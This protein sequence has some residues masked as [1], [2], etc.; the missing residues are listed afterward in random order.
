MKNKRLLIAALLTCTALFAQNQTVTVIHA[1]TLIDGH[2]DQ[3]LKNRTIVIRGN[4]IESV[5]DASSPVPAGAAVVD[6]SQATVLP[7]LID[8]HTHLFLQGEDPAL[9]GYDIQLLK[10]S[11]VLVPRAR[12][13]PL[14]VPWN[15]ASPRSATWKPKVQVTVTLAL[16]RR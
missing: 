5:G 8:T 16:S 1:G 14:A 3:P 6:L 13:F 15:R 12:R 10:F 9:G 7:G 11:S 4:R 2:S